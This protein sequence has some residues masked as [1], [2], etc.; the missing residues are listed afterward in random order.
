LMALG[1]YGCVLL[2][3]RRLLV[4]QHGPRKDTLLEKIE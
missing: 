2:L 1:L 3:E 4:W